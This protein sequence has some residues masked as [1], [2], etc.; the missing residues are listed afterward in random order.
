PAQE[1]AQATGK[2]DVQMGPQKVVDS[3]TLVASTRQQ[4]PR[5]RVRPQE[6]SV[7]VERITED[8]LA[9]A[10]SSAVSRGPASAA[11]TSDA[12]RSAPAFKEGKAD[13]T[14]VL[15]GS[16]KDGETGAQRATEVGS[17]SNVLIGG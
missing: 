8:L 1:A 11:D 16:D 5:H 7:V 2:P 10:E 13:G 6:A 14:I 9:F 17:V 4:A 15:I 3:G 12:M